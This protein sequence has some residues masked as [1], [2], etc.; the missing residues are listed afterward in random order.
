[1]TYYRHCP[2]R[3]IHHIWLSLS[4]TSSRVVRLQ[5]Q[6]RCVSPRKPRA[7]LES[8]CVWNCRQ[9]RLHPLQLYVICLLP[10][11]GLHLVGFEFGP[12]LLL[13]YAV[14]RASPARRHDDAGCRPL[15]V[16]QVT[17]SE[18]RAFLN[19]IHPNRNYASGHTGIAGTIK[20]TSGTSSQALRDESKTS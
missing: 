6:G 17:K 2:A 3:Q 4:A 16:I 11:P 20:L 8:H 12:L 9:N 7:G 1:M 18:L 5:C 15:P 14:G 13:W 10:S 19:N